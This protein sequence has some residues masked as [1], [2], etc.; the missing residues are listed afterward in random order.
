MKKKTHEKE[1]KKKIYIG[2]S[3]ISVQCERVVYFWGNPDSLLLRPCMTKLP[4]ILRG[5]P[6]H[7]DLCFYS[8]C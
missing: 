1:E 2:L 5:S 3:G 4:W 7:L 8:G 6:T